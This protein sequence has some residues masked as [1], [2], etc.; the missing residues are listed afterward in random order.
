[1]WPSCGGIFD[2][3]GKRER[4]EQLDARMSESGF[5]DNQERAQEIVQQVKG[6]R[7]WLEPYDALSA[8]VQGARE[9]LELVEAEPDAEMEAE[10]GREVDT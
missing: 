8:R 2:V 1:M 3:D 6:L 4:L 10:L 5:W 9:L 7:S